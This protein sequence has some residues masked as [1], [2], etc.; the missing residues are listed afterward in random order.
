M[1]TTAT[2]CEIC[3]FG[4]NPDSILCCKCITLYYQYVYCRY[5][6]F[7]G[8]RN[9]Y[10]NKNRKK[11]ILEQCSSEDWVCSYM[12]PI[13]KSKY[14]IIHFVITL[15]S[16]MRKYARKNL[17]IKQFNDFLDKYTNDKDV[18]LLE[19]QYKTT[20][21]MKMKMKVKDGFRQTT[22]DGYVK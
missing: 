12:K 19:K 22:I 9:L 3:G 5:I 21:V 14:L 1:I 6:D 17:I 13:C 16:G 4:I 7:N 10:C 8:I 2:S 20:K 15:T 11:I 18:P